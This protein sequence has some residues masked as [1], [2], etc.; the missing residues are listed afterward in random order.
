MR[1]KRARRA[2]PALG[3]RDGNSRK[4][5]DANAVGRSHKDHSGTTADARMDR[6]A[7]VMVSVED[8][9][10]PLWVVRRMHPSNLESGVKRWGGMTVRWVKPALWMKAMG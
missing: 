3:F 9:I 1:E 10:R 5:D 4:P 2:G 8:S 7:L 6:P